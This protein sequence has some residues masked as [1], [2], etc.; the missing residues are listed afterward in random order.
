[1]R[2]A[3]PGV[4]PKDLPEL[5]QDQQRIHDDFYEV[6]LTTL[7]QRYGLI[8]HFNHHYPLRTFRPGAKTLDVGAGLGSH[9]AYE[10]LD[11][12]EYVGLELRE[13]LARIMQANFPQAKTV[14]GD[15]QTR[16]NFPDGAFDRIL[17]IHVLEHLTDLPAAL[18]EISR[19]LSPTGHFSVLIPFDPGIA[20]ELARTISAR[21]IFERRY[22][23]SYDWF[24]ASEHINSWA[25]I[26]TELRKRFR[27]VHQQNFPLLIPVPNLNLVAGLTLQHRD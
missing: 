12:Q 8:D 2:F 26:L 21:R 17:A 7:P 3:Q 22:H 15:I 24:V 6:W 4:F 18:D 14:I 23:L 20:Y 13:H 5:T 25:E 16:L 27:I 11:E 1:M 10:R 9:A 19:L